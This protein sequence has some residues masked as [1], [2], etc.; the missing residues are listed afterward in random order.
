MPIFLTRNERSSFILE[1]PAIFSSRPLLVTSS[2]MWFACLSFVL[3][4]LSLYNVVNARFDNRDIFASV[5]R[6]N[7]GDTNYRREEGG[8]QFVLEINAVQLQA[9]TERLAAEASGRPI[10]AGISMIDSRVVQVIEC[11]T[12]STQGSLSPDPNN[13]TRVRLTY[14][15][16]FAPPS[17]HGWRL[18]PGQGFAMRGVDLELYQEFE[19]GERI[20]IDRRWN[21]SFEPGKAIDFSLE[22]PWPLYF[23]CLGWALTAAFF[24]G[25]VVL[26]ALKR[27]TLS[28]LHVYIF[29]LAIAINSFYAG[30]SLEKMSGNWAGYGVHLYKPMAHRLIDFGITEILA[31]FAF[32]LIPRFPDVKSSPRFQECLPL[33]EFSCACPSLDFS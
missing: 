21:V 4:I 1:R 9:L 11:S 23:V 5:S 22:T 18:V 19:A 26:K 24:G 28:N 16:G 27:T 7:G 25:F 33:C 8:V 32:V 29:G 30:V 14:F 31:V 6:R 17:L 10:I 20:I 3:M 13:A 15:K 2:K 12:E